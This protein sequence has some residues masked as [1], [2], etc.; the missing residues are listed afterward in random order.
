[1]LGGAAA[2]LGQVDVD[3]LH[4]G[5]RGHAAQVQHEVGDVGGSDPV[6]AGHLGL[7]PAEDT[8]GGHQLVSVL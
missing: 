3:Q 4:G 1:M 7:A 5:D 6:G 2:A 8:V